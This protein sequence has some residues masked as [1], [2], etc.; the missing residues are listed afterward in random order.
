MT[1]PRFDDQS[2]EFGLWL[3]RRSELDSSLG[4]IASNLDFIWMN[5]RTGLWMMIEEKRY[6]DTPE[7]RRNALSKH[8]RKAKAQ[9][10]VFEKIHS[11]AQHDP[12]YLGFHFVQFEKSCPEEGRIWWNRDEITKD[13][14][15][16]RLQ[17]VDGNDVKIRRSG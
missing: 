2:T 1:R 13:K 5:Y 14:L 10:T 15:V 17:A 8:C 7:K 11:A 3:R 9:R 16:R 12:T 6:Q 4:Y